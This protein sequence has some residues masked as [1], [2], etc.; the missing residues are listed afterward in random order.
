MGGHPRVG[1]ETSAV[2]IPSAS[3]NSGAASPPDVQEQIRVVGYGAVG[4]VLLAV[5]AIVLL[6]PGPLALADRVPLGLLFGIL[7]AVALY[8]LRCALA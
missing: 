7:M 2:A 3:F 4:I 1:R 5:T 6:W 8:R